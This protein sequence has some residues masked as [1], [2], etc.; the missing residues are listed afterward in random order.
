MNGAQ[1]CGTKTLG[2]KNSP[3]PRSEEHQIQSSNGKAPVCAPASCKLIFLLDLLLFNFFYAS[4]LSALAGS[5]SWKFLRTP[6]VNGSGESGEC[7]CDGF[8]NTN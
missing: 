3:S 8:S 4:A 6:L 5:S 2:C 1:V 7:H